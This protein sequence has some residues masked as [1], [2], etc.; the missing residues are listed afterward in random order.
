MRG[1]S[2]RL[3]RPEAVLARLGSRTPL[4]PSVIHEQ[5]SVQL[6][7][8]PGGLHGVQQLLGLDELR[9]P[10]SVFLPGH[11]ASD[12]CPL[13]LDLR[14]HGGCRSDRGVGQSWAHSLTHS[15]GHS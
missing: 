5:L 3:S 13:P 8:A 4:P 12:V 10:L 2:P 15:P 1:T 6:L 7:V 9:V 14:V 11:Q